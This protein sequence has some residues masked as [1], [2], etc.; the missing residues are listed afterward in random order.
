MDDINFDELD[1]AVASAAQP[2]AV[3]VPD[4]QPVAAQTQQQPTAPAAVATKRRGQFMDMVH[5]SSDMNKGPA[6][7][8]GIR[9]QA[10]VVQPLNPSIVET[11][12]APEQPEGVDTLNTQLST[13]APAAAPSP[14]TEY[15]WPDPLDTQVSSATDSDSTTVEDVEN[16]FVEPVPATT[17][18]N[19]VEAGADETESNQLSQAE[20]QESPFVEGA[21]VEKRPLG[22]FAT[23]PTEGVASEP[24]DEAS[25]EAE[26][27]EPTTQDLE[28]AEVPEQ[29]NEINESVTPDD[30]STP[31]ENEATETAE[32]TTDRP[33]QVSET[34]LPQPDEG[35]AQ[36]I[37]QQYRT[38]DQV[39]VVDPEEHAVFDTESYHQ[40]LPLP[41]KQRNGHKLLL[42]TLLAVV[43]LA[44]GAAAG[45][46]IFV[47][48]LL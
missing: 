5:P 9:R 7:S 17:E 35:M 31:V 43:M 39:T 12:T 23:M 18:Q 13:E 22:A 44:I 3:T 46:A 48:K 41:E 28:P 16:G 45:Y 37:P 11:S 2:N 25:A 42:Y 29:P 34:P 38:E 27:T 33:G 6:P 15:T 19:E 26:T 21:E 20:T 10:P 47:L 32:L 1:K 36:S 8:S 14:T 24:I 30:V 4:E 40:P